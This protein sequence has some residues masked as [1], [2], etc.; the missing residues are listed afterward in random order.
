MYKKRFR[1][2]LSLALAMLCGS[3]VTA[4]TVPDAGEF[5]PGPPE[6]TTVEYIKDYLQYAW[7]K[8]MR[9][10]ELGQQAQ[11]D[12]NAKAPYYLEAFSKAIDV[13]LSSTETPYIAELF[14]YCMEYGNKSIEQA[15]ISFPFFRRPY[16]RFGETSLIP[17]QENDYINESSF[18]SRE[19][20]MGWM[21]ALLLTEICPGKQ[22]QILN[23][24]YTFGQA[25]VITGYHWDSDVQAARLL[26]CALVT[27]LHNHTGVNGMIKSAKAEYAK[28]TGTSYISPSLTEETQQYYSNDDL[29]DAVKFLPAP[30]DTVSALMATD[31]SNFIE[32]K[33]VRP[34]DEGQIAINDV[35]SDPE[36][37]MEIYSSAFGRTL[38]ETTTPELYKMFQ[39]MSALGD[40]A[41]RSC[42]NYYKRPRPYQQLNEATAY[43]PAEN[44]K[45]NVGSYPSGHASASWL[46]ALVLSELNPNAEEAL[47]ARAYKYGQGRVVTGYVWQSDVEGGR[48]VGSA[49][50]ARLH[51][52]EE[53]MTQFER[54]KQELNATGVRAATVEDNTNEDVYTLGGVRLPSEPDQKGVYIQGNKKVMH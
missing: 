32:G 28:V 2:I 54:V 7:G 34:T 38:S 19:A 46:Y 5:L 6:E 47:L 17:L 27:R 8:T 40:G 29:P 24:G 42:K 37:F 1:F 16:A 31:M 18:P 41:T 36:Y 45:R 20:L 25:S 39:N 22:D 52:S 11:N 35:D 50:Y 3:S 51:N 26:A 44:L 12:F 10:T 21:Y 14:E 9:G 4:Q 15:K 33:F 48:L 30:P 53:F 23:C 49:V 13:P 43:P